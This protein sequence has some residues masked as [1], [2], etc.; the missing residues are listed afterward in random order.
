MLVGEGVELGDEPV[1]AAEPQLRFD[2][3]FDR[4]EVQLVQSFERDPRA[5]RRA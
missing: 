2:A 1:V 5:R 4:A 3:P